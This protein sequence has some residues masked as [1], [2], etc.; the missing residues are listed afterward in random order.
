[1]F[2]QTEKKMKNVRR[3]QEALLKKGMR[4]RDVDGSDDVDSVDSDRRKGE[5]DRETLRMSESIPSRNSER[6]MRKRAWHLEKVVAFRE[7][8]TER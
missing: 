4:E 3:I 7:T 1:M 2:F 5:T 8:V 6:G